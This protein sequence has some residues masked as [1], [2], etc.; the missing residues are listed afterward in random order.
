MCP[1]LLSHGVREAGTRQVG[2]ARAR[3]V[4]SR[5]P[6]G[7]FLQD[8]H[9]NNGR[10]AGASRTWTCPPPPGHRLSIDRPPCLQGHNR[11]RAPRSAKVSCRPGEF[12]RAG[13]SSSACRSAG[14]SPDRGSDRVDESHRGLVR[15]RRS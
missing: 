4:G 14:F 10:A 8:W 5:P 11:A 2:R 3:T 12:D 7:A 15:S 1:P 6:P 9:R 13:V